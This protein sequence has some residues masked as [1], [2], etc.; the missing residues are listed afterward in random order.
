MAFDF[1]SAPTVGDIH[2]EAGVEYQYAGNGVWDLAGGGMMTDYVLKAGDTMT[3]PLLINGPSAPGQNLSIGSAAGIRTISLNPSSGNHAGLIE[4]WDPTNGTTRRGYI[5]YG[6]ANDSTTPANN[7]LNINPEGGKIHING[8]GLA[9]QENAGIHWGSTS[10]KTSHTDLSEGICLYGWGGTSKFGFNITSGTM[11]YCVENA[12]N[13]HCFTVG[14]VEKA[15]I[16]SSGLE[17]KGNITGTGSINRTGSIDASSHIQ[18]AGG[19]YATGCNC[20][21]RSNG[22]YIYQA[23]ATSGLYNAHQFQTSDGHANMWHQHNTSSARNDEGWIRTTTEN[24]GYSTTWAFQNSI[25][26][27]PGCDSNGAASA[28][29]FLVKSTAALKKGIRRDCG[30]DMVGA[31]DALKPVA[32]RRNDDH[33]WPPKDADGNLKPNPYPRDERERFGFVVE[34]MADKPLLKNVVEEVNYGQ[35]DYAYDMAQVLA[36]CVAKIKTLEAEIE[37]LKKRK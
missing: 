5:G 7:Y 8:N 32:Y 1:P 30:P 19:L 28:L 34:D 31:F 15:V 18:A 9:M 37:L 35:K 26:S 21:V 24:G 10:A 14:N 16:N 4:F 17:V 20:I 2:T 12:A 22:V 29:G 3:G 36:L 27:S 6:L 13:R 33:M 25:A 11:G 23:N